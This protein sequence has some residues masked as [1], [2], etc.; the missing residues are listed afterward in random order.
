MQPLY[1]Q[2]NV[3]IQIICIKDHIDVFSKDIF[4]LLLVD[5]V[6]AYPLYQILLC[7]M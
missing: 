5:G 2:Q 7:A 4:S 1:I 3:H 6:T